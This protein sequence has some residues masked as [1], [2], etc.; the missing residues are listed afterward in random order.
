MM[1]AVVDEDERVRYGQMIFDYLAENPLQIGFFL[2]IPAPLLFNKNLRNTP[3][4]NAVI[5]WDTYGLSTYH[6]EAFFYEGGVRA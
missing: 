4:P 1:T 3:R 5:G 6:P 2:E